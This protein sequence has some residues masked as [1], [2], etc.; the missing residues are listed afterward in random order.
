M[1][2]NSKKTKRVAIIITLIIV[3]AILSVCSYLIYS[4]KNTTSIHNNSNTDQLIA[5]SEQTSRSHE[6][7]SEPL[8]STSNEI[9]NEAPCDGNWIQIKEEKINLEVISLSQWGKNSPPSILKESLSKNNFFILGHNLC[10]NNSCYT[11]GSQFSTI[12]SLNS[13]ERVQACISN[14][15]YN[16]EVI[17]TKPVSDTEVEVMGDWL[18]SPSITLMTSYGLCKDENCSSTYMRWIVGLKRD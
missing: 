14:I 4:A 8:P 11:Q 16:A 9:K 17:I 7:N 2:R 1:N 3:S 12:I 13:G 6:N 10:T 5:T 18:N 15:K